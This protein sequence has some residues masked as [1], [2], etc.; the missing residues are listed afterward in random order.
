MG[1]QLLE[2][3]FKDLTEGFRKIVTKRA[4]T[5]FHLKMMNLEKPTSYNLHTF[6]EVP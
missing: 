1:L 3:E 2:E 5:R 6:S 4:V